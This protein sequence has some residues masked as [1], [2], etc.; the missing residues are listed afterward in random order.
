MTIIIYKMGR[1]GPEEVGQ[2]TGQTTS[3]NAV[4]L[5]VMRSQLERS[6]GRA[7]EEADWLKIYGS[8]SHLWASKPKPLADQ[9][10]QGVSAQTQRAKN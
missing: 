7:P 8:G 10:R 4:L 3:G 1:E 9:V 5:V 6:L 2:I